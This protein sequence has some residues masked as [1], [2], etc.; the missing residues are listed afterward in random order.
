MDGIS[1]WEIATRGLVTWHLAIT[2]NDCPCVYF[3]SGTKDAQYVKEWEAAN[4]PLLI[5]G[6]TVHTT[7]T[8]IWLINERLNDPFVRRNV[9]AH[10]YAH[11]LDLKHVEIKG[12]LM[13]LEMDK[14]KIATITKADLELLCAKYR[15]TP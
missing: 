11:A 9:A 13:T 14:K 5:Q 12:A 6:Y 10:E 7:P 3:M 8:V 1:M 4:K 15:C 2:V